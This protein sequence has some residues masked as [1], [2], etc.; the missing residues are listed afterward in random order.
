MKH[1]I[2]FK[3]QCQHC[4]T[5]QQ[6]YIVDGSPRLELL[7]EHCMRCIGY[8]DLSTEEQVNWGI[9]LEQDMRENTK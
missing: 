7:C 3:W 8:D 6:E 2:A 4:G 5:K 1:D 9:A